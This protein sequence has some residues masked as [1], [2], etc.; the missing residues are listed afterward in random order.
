GGD[1]LSNT[2]ES[3]AGYYSIVSTEMKIADA[4]NKD[5]A[6]KAKVF[7]YYKQHYGKDPKPGQNDGS[8]DLNRDPAFVRQ[9]AGPGK[10][11]E[12][13]ALEDLAVQLFSDVFDKPV[14]VMGRDD[15]KAPGKEKDP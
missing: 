7:D 10:V 9:D 3:F 2:K 6:L 4:I 13:H 8:F 1:T 12:Q 11:T 5:P 14:Q 15:P